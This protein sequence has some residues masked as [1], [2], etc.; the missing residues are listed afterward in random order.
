[1]APKRP[2]ETRSP[3]AEP[4]TRASVQRQSPDSRSASPS[5]PGSVIARDV[6]G[7]AANRAERSSSDTRQGGTA[8]LRGTSE[9][10]RAAEGA[11]TPQT[12]DSGRT[13][14]AGAAE[15]PGTSSPAAV[16]APPRPARGTAGPPLKPRTPH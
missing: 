7:E 2:R 11:K 8:A 9:A 10:T 4:T 15:R 16:A 13:P 1:P 5:S 12:S 3:Q 14:G 6:S